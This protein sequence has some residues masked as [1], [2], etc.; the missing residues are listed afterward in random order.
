MRA[1][2]CATPGYDAKGVRR[3]LRCGGTATP[4]L[5][6]IRDFSCNVNLY[7]P[8]LSGIRL[9]GSTSILFEYSKS[10]PAQIDK[11]KKRGE[12]AS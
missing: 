7:F 6:I 9:L 12:P 4:D 5:L 2:N 1:T 10:S 8:Y 11:G 3:L